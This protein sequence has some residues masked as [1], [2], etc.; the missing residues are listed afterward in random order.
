MMS[1]WHSCVWVCVR[2]IMVSYVH[3]RCGPTDSLGLEAGE[4]AQLWA[5]SR[6]MRDF[7]LR[8]T[9]DSVLLLNTL[10]LMH[11]STANVSVPQVSVWKKQQVRLFPSWK[12][13]CA[14]FLTLTLCCHISTHIDCFPLVLSVSLPPW[15]TLL[16]CNSLQYILFSFFSLSPPSSTLCPAEWVV[17]RVFVIRCFQLHSPSIAIIL[18]VQWK[19]VFG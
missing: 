14:S 3:S 10:L 8:S 19:V 5:L 12:K 13:S 6:I 16:T 9:G 18:M 4:A 15:Q 7:P 2:W 11:P 17:P 1:L